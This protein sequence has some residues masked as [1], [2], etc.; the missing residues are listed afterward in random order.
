M[1]HDAWFFIGI[2]AFI[3]VI[4]VIIGGPKHPI[5][6]TGPTLSLPKSLGTGTYLSFP[7]APFSIGGSSWSVQNGSSTNVPSLVGGALYGSPSIYRGIVMM[8]E[9][10]SGAGSSEPS[11]EYV[12]LSVSDTANVPVDITGW[13]I[14]SGATG[15]GAVIPKGTETPTSG[16]INEA[17]DIVLTPGE[18]AILIS[19]RSPIGASFKENKCIGY[20]SSF[21]NF[22]PVLPQV[23]PS[24]SDELL[25]NYGNYYIRD[26]VCIEYVNKLNRCQTA[27]TPPVGITS[28][29]QSFVANYLNYNGC[30]TTHQKDADFEGT[31]WR[32]YLGHTNSIWRTKNELVKLLDASGK[33]VDAFSY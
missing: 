26:S 14:T 27:L 25:A 31:V 18:K 24:P 21:Q 7:I 15:N 3:F 6:F 8:S 4:W 16:V 33:T 10:V 23:C 12:E 22:Y 20:F 30:L 29:C 13:T 28:A 32:V 9:S 19:G 17:Q 1:E 2:F 5:A 11:N